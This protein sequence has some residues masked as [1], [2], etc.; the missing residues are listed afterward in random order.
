MAGYFFLESITQKELDDFQAF[1]HKHYANRNSNESELLWLDAF[2]ETP[3]KESFRKALQG[4]DVQD[5]HNLPHHA[6]INLPATNIPGAKKPTL[7]KKAPWLHRLQIKPAFQLQTIREGLL[8]P[9]ERELFKRRVPVRANWQ[10][11]W[12]VDAFIRMLRKSEIKIEVYRLPEP[13]LE[14]ELEGK[15]ADK[16]TF[17]N[18]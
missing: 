14:R 4:K 13:F 1:F 15:E 17:L 9:A 12:K 18:E 5:R 16:R 8:S 10:K 3:N 6:K 2:H 7:H 11:I